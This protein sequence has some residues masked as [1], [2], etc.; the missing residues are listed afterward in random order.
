[1]IDV[2]ELMD[3]P[4]FCTTITVL[5]RTSTVGTTGRNALA[6]NPNTVTAIVQAGNGETLKRLPESA[7][8]SDW[9]TVYSKFVFTADGMGQYPDI[10]QWNSKRYVVKLKIDYSNWGEGYTRA[11]C[12]I[13]GGGNG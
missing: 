3:D 2:S 8:L 6:E 9:I 12:L 4:D 13:E 1:M 5:R 11:D 7:Q 10:V